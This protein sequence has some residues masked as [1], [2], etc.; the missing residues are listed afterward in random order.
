MHHI[1]TEGPD[2]ENSED[3][4]IG[5]EDFKDVKQNRFD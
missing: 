5:K 1:G 4:D 3:L 2:N